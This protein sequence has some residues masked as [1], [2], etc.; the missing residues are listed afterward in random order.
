MPTPKEILEGL[1]ESARKNG[2]AFE[3]LQVPTEFMRELVRECFP[4]TPEQFF[5]FPIKVNTDLDGLAEDVEDSQLS[6]KPRTLQ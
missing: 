1:V 2:Q 3:D 5:G 4:Q 6:A